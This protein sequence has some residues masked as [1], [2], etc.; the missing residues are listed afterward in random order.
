MPQ[1][2]QSLHAAHASLPLPYPCLPCPLPPRPQVLEAVALDQSVPPLES[3]QEDV[4]QYMAAGQVEGA[5]ELLGGL[6]DALGLGGWRGLL[7]ACEGCCMYG[8]HV[9]LGG[10]Q[11]VHMRCLLKAALLDMAWVQCHDACSF[12]GQVMMQPALLAG[13]MPAASTS[14]VRHGKRPHCGALTALLCVPGLAAEPPA[15]TAKAGSK[16]AKPEDATRNIATYVASQNW[17]DLAQGGWLAKLTVA[18]LDMY[19]EYHRLKKTGNKGSK[20]DR[21]KEHLGL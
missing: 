12:S 2:A 21:I 14:A 4:M 18:D 20:V 15:G 13:T 3:F 7:H 9:A 11:W 8:A 16:R 5:G 19:L 10:E 17:K 6:R 1:L